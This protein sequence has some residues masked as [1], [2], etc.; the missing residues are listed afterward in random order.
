LQKYI[1]GACIVHFS[2]WVEEKS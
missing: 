2:F 1:I